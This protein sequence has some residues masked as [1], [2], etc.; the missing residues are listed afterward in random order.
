MSQ[1]IIYLEDDAALG[2]VTSRTLTKKGFEVT[3]VETLLAFKEAF[4]KEEY[5]YAL[6]DLKI[7]TDTSLE[8]LNEIPNLIEI[9]TVFLTGYGTIRT[10]VKAIKLGAANFLTKP[11]SISEIISA[12]ENLDNELLAKEENLKP[13]TLKKLE[14]E[15]IQTALDDND[16]NIS[17]AARQLNMHRRTLQRKLQKR[18][19]END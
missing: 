12:F 19:L 7:G 2:L 16:G 3:H 15:A 17:A 10:A 1:K 14:W 18:H 9:P 11:A 5:D 13:L 8:L 6:L 4:N